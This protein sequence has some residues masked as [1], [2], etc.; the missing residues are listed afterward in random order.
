MERREFLKKAFVASSGLL[1]TASCAKAQESKTH[2]NDNTSRP[3]IILCMADDQ[4]WGDTAYNGHAVLKTPNLDQMARSGIRFD[5]FYAGAPVCSPTRG[6]CLTGR[7]PNRYGIPWANRGHLKKEEINLAEV[8]KQ[9]GYATGHFGK[10]HLGT[11]SPV[12]SGK[13]GR[14]PKKNYMTP[15]MSG[16]DEWFSTEYSVNTWDPYAT[17]YR[18]GKRDPRTFY[19]HNGR[20]IVD[21]PAEGLTGCDSRII[22][23]KAIPFIENAAKENKPFFTVIWFHTP[24]GPVFG[25]PEYLKMYPNS[26]EQEQHYYAAV[27]A[28]DDQMGRLRKTLEKIGVADNTMLWYCSDNGPEGSAGKTG[29]YQGE[30]PFRGRKRSLYEGGVRVPGIL[31]WPAVVKEPRVVD[32]PCVTSD[33]FPTIV[34]LLGYK[35]KGKARPYDGLDLMDTIKGKM[36]QRNKPIG[37]QAQEQNSLTDDRYKLVHNKSVNNRKAAAT[38]ELYDLIDDPKETK[39][40]A[41]EKSDVVNDM[42]KT[43][44]EW[45]QS[46]KR[47]AEGNDYE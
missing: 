43:L 37:F 44:L 33:Y 15:G 34:G 28:L 27:T 8:L 20:N 6:S 46:C 26:S 30:T 39:N 18:E 7:N 21:G 24:H 32:M 14:D 10:W 11:L 16:F 45:Q 38:W 47:S 9:K 35:I 2:L 1:F 22:M 13:R 3:N 25:G 41:G 29:R 23:D 19:Y 36:S 12:Y 17:N 5:R 40:I 42:K 31:V 4:G